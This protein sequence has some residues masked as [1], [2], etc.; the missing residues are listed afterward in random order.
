MRTI[1]VYSTSTGLAQLQ[2][3]ATTWGQLMSD[4]ASN[5]IQYHGMKAV[6]SKNNTSLERDD[7]IL[8]TESFVLMLSPEKTKSGGYRET[9][10]AIQLIIAKHGIVAKNHF[11]SGKNYT[12]K[13]AS[14]LE[15][16]LDSWYETFNE[17]EDDEEDELDELEAIVQRLRNSYYYDEREDDFELAIDLIYGNTSVQKLRVT[18]CKDALNDESLSSDEKAWIMKMLNGL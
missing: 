14:E 9:R 17:G 6:E 15:S 10:D 13:S 16:L 2:S 7:A 4:L 1:K 12:L 5:N 8:P 18:I 11:N 3:A